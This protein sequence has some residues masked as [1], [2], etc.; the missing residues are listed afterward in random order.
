MLLF[1]LTNEYKSIEKVQM[2]RPVCN[3]FD[4]KNDNEGRDVKSNY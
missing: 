1:S 3:I 2:N 4:V